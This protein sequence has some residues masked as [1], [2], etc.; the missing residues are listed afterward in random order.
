M[1]DEPPSAFTGQRVHKL[2][3]AALQRADVVGEF[4][5]PMLA[6]QQALDIHHR[7]DVAS[8]PDEIRATKPSVLKRIL[9]A[10]WFQERT[11]FMDTSQ[12]EPRQL[13]T[14]AH[15][16]SHV[17]CPWHAQTLAVIDTE[18]ELVRRTSLELLEAEANLGAGALIFQG[19]RFHRHALEGQVSIRAPLELARHYGASRT[20]AVHYYAQEH[21]DAVALLVAGRFCQHD[22]AVPVWRSV[23]SPTFAKRFGR[24]TDL[25][26]SGRLRV[27]GDGPDAP[28]AGII[29]QA[30][31][32]VDPP[33]VD[34]SVPDRDQTQ[35]PFIAEAFYNQHVNLVLVTEKR[36]RRL[37]R[38]ARLAS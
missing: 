34:L 20:A 35:H 6:V 29:Q 4:P 15:E 3:E 10:V 5:T 21:P 11:V 17:M 37:G 30:R 28:L 26:P 19:G 32:A 16:A 36:A 25:L 9:G 38:R 33:Q 24:L 13:F 22:G 18:D 2:A 31:L 7:I 1:T 8:L 14:D 12:S 23:E 27:I